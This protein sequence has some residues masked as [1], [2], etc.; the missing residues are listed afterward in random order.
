MKK[1]VSLLIVAIFVVAGTNNA[2]GIGSII[3]NAQEISGF[4]D[5]PVLAN[6]EISVVVNGEKLVMDVEPQEFPVYDANG[7]YVGDR[8]MVPIRAISEKLNCDVHWEEETA[9]VVL[10]RKNNLYIM[11]EGYDTAFHLDGIGLSK[12]YTMDVPPTIVDGRTL[13]PVRA[14]AEIMGAKVEWIEETNTVDIKYDMGDIEE[15]AG[16]AAQCT[17]YQYRL[18][19]EYDTYKDL[20]NGTLDG[21]TGKIVMEDGGEIEFELYPQIAPATCGKFI[22]CAKSGFYENKIFHRVIKD[23]VI[24]GGG[25]TKDGTWETYSNEY[26]YGEFVMNGYFNILSHTRGILSFARAQENDS[27]TQQFFICHQD[28]RNLNG[29]YAAFG[30]VTSGMEVVDKIASAE[31]DE[32][33]E[34]VSP[35]I[36]K[37][38]IINE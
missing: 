31:T 9:G 32:N 6:D 29:N 38:V 26:L 19:D 2:D 36:V 11:W 25:K 24:Q 8:V 14:V 10:Y 3:S 13:L 4:L 17:I 16:M 27:A 34:P 12:G 33:D 20:V 1:I 15:N 18:K 7:G 5:F 35:I 21:V 28:A 37:Q 30:I 23:F 22:E